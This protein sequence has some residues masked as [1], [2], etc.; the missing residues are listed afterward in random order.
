MNDNYDAL[1]EFIGDALTP[2]LASIEKAAVGVA[3]E[4]CPNLILGALATQKAISQAAKIKKLAGQINVTIHALGILRCL[5]FI[6]EDGEVIQYLSL[7]AGN[8]GRKF[9]LETN[10][11]IAEFKFINWKG[12]AQSIRQNSVF[13][14]FFE[15]SVA[16]TEKQKLLY[17]LGTE[18]ALKFFGGGRSLNSVLSKN[19]ATRFKFRE[20]YGDAYVTVREYYKD[21]GDSVE[22]LDVS[23]WLPELVSV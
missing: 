10:R 4:D 9:D 3:A 18:Q 8:T 22:I 16:K 14:D 19:E 2:A 6:L 7:G 5:P 20:L 17:L 15:L 11:R 1:N 12:G 13:K 23:E 21:H